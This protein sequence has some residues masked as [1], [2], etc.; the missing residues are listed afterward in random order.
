MLTH[1]RLLELKDHAKRTER[2]VS[3]QI[4]QSELAALVAEL[5]ASRHA[6]RLSRPILDEYLQMLCR[7]HCPPCKKGEFFDYSQL[8]EQEFNW[9]IEA[10]DALDAVEALKGKE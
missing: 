9:I 6:L 10:Q 4:R 7:S 3:I 8:E 1:A 2:W 5:I